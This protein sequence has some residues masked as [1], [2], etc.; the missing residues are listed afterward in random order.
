MFSSLLNSLQVREFLAWVSTIPVLGRLINRIVTNTIA[1]ATKPRPRPYSLWWPANSLDARSSADQ[2]NG[3]ITDYASWPS[4]TDRSFSARHL[5][6]A[7]EAFIRQL[8]PDAPYDRK[9]G[10]AGAITSLFARP[11]DSSGQSLMT[12]DR[13]SVLF[14]FFA[15]WFTDSILRIDPKDR[16]RNTSNHDVDLCQIYGL[17]EQ[18]TRC[19]RSCEHGHLRS[20]HINGQEFPDYL[21]ERDS[22]GQ[23][24]VKPIYQCSVDS[25]GNPIPG[26]GLYPHGST[27]WVRQSLKGSFGGML[28]DAEVELRL[29]KMY[30]TGL[31]RGNSSVGYVA[32]SLVF[33]REHNRICDELFRQN[34]SWQDEQLFQT[35]RMINICLL[36]KLTVEDYINHIA[37]QRIFR[38]DP[39]F[40][41]QQNWYRTNWIAL[42]FDLLYRWHGLVPDSL[43]VNKATVPANEYRWN[44]GLLEILGI[45]DLINAA[46]AQ[47]AGRISLFNNPVF[48][49]E[50][51]YRTIQMGRDFR[52]R[53]FNDYREAFGLSRLTSFQA[54]TPN[55]EIADRLQSLYGSIENLELVVG[56]FAEAPGEG[57]L[58]GELMRTMVAYDAFTQIYTN[59]LLSRS[60]HT[61]EHLTTYGLK[62]IEET[63]TITKLVSRN[64]GKDEIVNATL[65]IVSA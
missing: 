15:Q 50:S 43:I 37:G 1:S 29:D 34:P 22:N 33:L 8:P 56:L 47:A 9:T 32:L 48:L 14:M 23:W 19:L 18:E 46:A 51:E 3:P 31:E 20:Q 44:N 40:A 30:A 58:F 6:P 13:S 57:G 24:Q 4:L 65:G 42:E 35:A 28:T 11:R 59:P 52:L 55:K 53:S 12:P 49:M 62:L 26:R 21:G 41:E 5:D 60:I 27:E 39:S 7:P 63:N 36:L 61:A 45:S 38:L 54:L 64:V 16:R 17:N 25:E 2:T 10:S